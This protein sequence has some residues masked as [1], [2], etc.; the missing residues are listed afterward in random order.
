[1]TEAKANTEAY[2]QYPKDW[3]H[4]PLETLVIEGGL[5]R[6]PFG[7][8]LTKASFTK[9]GYKVYEQRNAIYRS[10]E[11][12]RYYI[13]QAKFKELERFQVCPGEMIVSCSGTIGQIFKL[14]ENS[15]KGV[16]NQALLKIRLDPER[17]HDDY[18]LHVFR[19]DEFQ[20]R[21][22]ENTHGGAMQNLVGMPIFRQTTIA[23]P[24]TI[25]EQRAIA[26]A[27]GDVD[28]LIGSLERLI[29]KKRDIKQAVIQQLLTGQTR[30][31]GFT[32]RWRHVKLGTLGQF[33]K[34]SGISRSQAQSGSIPCVRYGELYTS[35][36]DVVQTFESF[37]SLG[38]AITAL[39]LRKGDILFAGSGETKEEIGKCAA[40]VNDLEAYAGG[41][42]VVLR[43]QSE[44]AQYLGYYLNTPA[45]ASQK[46][47]KGQG[48]A[49]VHISAKAL[50][51]IDC[52]IPEVHEQEAI[53]EVITSIDL[54]MAHLDKRLAKTRNIKQGMMQQLLTGKVRL[55]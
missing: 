15:P 45:I 9:Q 14:P 17:I 19:S 54:E 47:S 41:D 42:I 50:A 25:Q 48:D 4:V 16:I 49:V 36:H 31:P 7:G 38:V 5:V 52:H 11:L 33:L 44:C 22:K 10:T 35:H 8:S 40:F 28:E 24:P 26:E 39:R 43:N 21:I 1:M 23:C 55:V 3:R 34:G 51:D 32:E 27:L 37:I 2:S 13:G 18:F 29:A 12:G 20:Q 30:L 6:G 46:A 53:A